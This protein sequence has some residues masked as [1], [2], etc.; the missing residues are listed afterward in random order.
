MHTI[1]KLKRSIVFILKLALF[2]ALFGIFFGIFGIHNPWLWN[3][4][5]TTGV[6]MVTFIVLGIA[7][8][9]VYGGYAVGA[10]KSKPIVHSMALATIITDL[11]THLQLSIMNTSQFNNDHFVYETP[12]L[13]LLVMVLQVIVI[14]FFSYFGNF[15]YFSLE[16]PERCCVI[17]SSRE[18]LGSIIP[19]I[20]RFKKQYNITETV[21]YDSPKVLDVIA[22]NDTV[23]LYDVPTRE[24]TSLIDFCYQ[25]Q[26]N[27]YYNF[28]MIDV[29]SQGAKYVTL[30]DKSLVMHMA[31]DL[32]MEQ[33]IIKRLMDISISLFA[34]VLTSPIMLVC[35]IAIKAEDGGKVFYKQKRLTKYGRVFQVYKFRTMKE[36]NSIH[37]SVTENDDRITK[38][39][40]ILRKFRIDELP[41]MLN[42]LKGD[43]TVVGPR[44][45]M[46]ENVEKYTSDLPEFSYR[47]RMKAGLTGLAQISGKYNTSPKDKLVMDLMYI[48]NYSIWQDLKLIFQ[49]ITVFLKASESTE[50]FGR[51]NLYDFDEEKE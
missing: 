9:S 21:R 26:K 1:K 36:E 45:E 35:A 3:L 51:E 5:R 27:I 46:L 7:L 25:T 29:V 49:T 37:K 10:Q 6:T 33:R 13:L 19:K 18:S 43:M 44:P 50:A 24:R 22:R 48:E 39:G 38:V 14:V 15:I 47:L 42:I 30:D 2:A 12:H 11:V 8:M 20:K 41:Q 17:S 23:F 34:L 16:P 31:K 40:N 28:E 32:T 4:S